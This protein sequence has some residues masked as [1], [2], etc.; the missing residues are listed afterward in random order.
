MCVCI[1]EVVKGRRWGKKEGRQSA[2]GKEERK[3]KDERH[4][5]QPSHPNEL[6]WKQQSTIHP[7]RPTT[8]PT[9]NQQRSRETKMIIHS[10]SSETIQLIII[11]SL[12]NSILP[13]CPDPDHHYN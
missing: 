10:Y 11:P 13:D 6:N 9:H 3:Q 12:M 4:T 5:T 1:W 8:Q 7:I 2:R